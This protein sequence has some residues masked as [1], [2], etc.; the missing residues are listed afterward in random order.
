VSRLS[1]ADATTTTTT[2]DPVDE[3]REAV[4]A[5][6]R[7]EL[8]DA[9]VESFVRPDD[10]VWVRVRR[11]AWREAGRVAREAGFT[12]FCFLSAIDWLPSPF[13]KDEDSQE[14]VE[15]SGTERKPPGEMRTGFAGGVTRFQMLA[16]L[17]K[18]RQNLGLFLKADLE[19]PP[20]VESWVPIFAG[21]D[22]HEREAWEMYGIDF[23][24]HPHLRHIYLP[25]EFEGFPL[26]K[27]FPLLARRVKPWPGI[28]DVEVMPGEDAPATPE[29]VAEA[30]T[31]EG[32]ASVELPDAGD[33][34]TAADLAPSE[35]TGDAPAVGDPDKKPA[36]GAPVPAHGE[37]ASMDQLQEGDTAVEEA[38]GGGVDTE[39][40]PT[41]EA[42]TGRPGQGGTGQQA[43]DA[44]KGPS[45]RT[46]EQPSPG[47]PEEREA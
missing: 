1:S 45:D 5:T 8:G 14:D 32:P 15:A 7:T 10:D 46:R 9:V 24:G 23:V 12:Y 17:V 36:V 2:A 41:G 44:A 30:D 43:T 19:D 34:A 42:D 3:V 39:G 29:A 13:G 38:G 22:W 20:T 25:G 47:E 26:R 4:L 35:P 28:V 31:G 11:E 18:P 21:A 33:A 40:I 16:R 6:L 37:V 27:D